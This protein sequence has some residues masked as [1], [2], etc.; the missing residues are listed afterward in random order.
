MDKDALKWVI[1]GVLAVAV[2]V[3]AFGA[4]IWVG[5]ERARF[6]F[7]WAEDY[8]RNFGGPK[9]GFFGNFPGEEF[10]GGHGI[11]GS[12]IKIDGNTLIVKDQRNTENTVNVFD[13][14]IIVDRTKNLKLSDLK[15][16]QNIVVIGSPNSESQIDAKLIRILPPPPIF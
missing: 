14:T 2:V 13:N 7:R 1:T 15:V 8:H 6:S 5:Q 16:D 10:T 11:F 4:G 9:N 3:L 12:I